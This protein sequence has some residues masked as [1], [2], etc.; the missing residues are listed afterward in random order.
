MLCDD[1]HGGDPADPDPV[2]AKAPETGFIGRPGRGQ[3]AGLCGECHTGPTAFFGRGP[4]HDPG[5]AGNP[6]CVTCHHNHAVLDATPA[7]MDTACASCHRQE[8]AALR[9]ASD[10]RGLIGAAGGRIV[11]ARVRFDSLAALE[12]ALGRS[13]SLGA[14]AASALRETAPRTHALDLALLEEPLRAVDAELAAWGQAMDRAESSRAGRRRALW[15]V[16]AFVAA[17][18]V[19]LWVRHRRLSAAE[20]S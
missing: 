12:P 20:G 1:C 3:I 13:A 14:A 7:L 6:T 18:L 2:T 11:R 16:W 10:L 9:R 17:N 19:L 4:H 5:V 15:A 8:P